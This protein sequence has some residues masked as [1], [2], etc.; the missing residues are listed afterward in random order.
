MRRDRCQPRRR[1]QPSETKVVSSASAQASEHVQMVSAATEQLTASIGEI[2]AQVAKSSRIAADAVVEARRTD[3][4][5]KV[6]RKRRG[7]S[8]TWSA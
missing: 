4:R 2:N 3:A 1:R 6:W 8:A 5:C 7:G